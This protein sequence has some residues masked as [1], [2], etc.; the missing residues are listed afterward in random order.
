[1]NAQHPFRHRRARCATRPILHWRG[2]ERDTPFTPRPWSGLGLHYRYLTGWWLSPF[3]KPASQL[4]GIGRP[5]ST[6]SGRVARGSLPRHRQADLA[7]E[8]GEAW[9]VPIAQDEGIVGVLRYVTL[10]ERRSLLEG[11]CGLR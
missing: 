7:A 1:M 9:I 3:P 8:R 2:D 6:G 4:A 10:L 5:P 11:C